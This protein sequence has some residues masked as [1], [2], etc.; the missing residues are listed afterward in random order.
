MTLMPHP[1]PHLHPED[2]I[3]LGGNDFVYIISHYCDVIM[4]AVAS[5]IT[6]LTIVYS[7]IKEK[8]KAA[9]HWPLCG[10]TQVTGEFPAQMAGNT[11]NVFVWWRYHDQTMDCEIW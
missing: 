3:K 2:I 6:S 7:T 11:E 5:Q 10:H 9:R 8:I 4:G 1:H